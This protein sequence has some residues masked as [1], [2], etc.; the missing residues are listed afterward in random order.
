MWHINLR[1][2]VYGLGDDLTLRSQVRRTPDS[3]HQQTGTSR[4]VKRYPSSSG[5][6]TSNALPSSN[7]Y[8]NGHGND[9]RGWHEH[10]SRHSDAPSFNSHRPTSDS[11]QHGQF[12]NLLPQP[13]KKQ[14]LNMPI[15][16]LTSTSSQRVLILLLHLTFPLLQVS[17][18]QTLPFWDS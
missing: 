14:K 10:R 1:S 18:K 15:T 9:H 5:P 16:S 12:S 2:H 4:T 3:S 6:I 7:G 13:G 11:Q 17:S 8:A